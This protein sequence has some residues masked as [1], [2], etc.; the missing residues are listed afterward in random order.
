MN[1]YDVAKFA[2]V[3]V[4]TVSRVINGTDRVSD[5]TRK[6]VEDAIEKLNFIPNDVARALASSKTNYIGIMV[7]NIRN[8]FDNQSAYALERNLKARGIVS[9]LCNTSDNEN[10]KLDYLKVLRE[11]KVD[12]IITVGSTYGEKDFLDELEDISR[13]I[14]IVM[15]N[16]IGEKKHRN[17]IYVCCDEV[18]AIDQSLSFFKK[19]GY[20]KPIFISKGHKNQTRAYKAKKTGFIE[21]LKKNYPK[22]D[23]IEFVVKDFNEDVDQIVSLIKKEKIDCIQFEL[24]SL[25]VKFYKYFLKNGIRVPEDIGIC[26]FDNDDITNY[27]YKPISSIDQNIEKQAKIAIENLFRLEKGEKFEQINLIKAKFVQKQSI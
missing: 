26:G 15:L 19:K 2:D 10:E 4:A 3:S 11:K 17:M 16:V 23:F 6:K 13:E 8:Y 5:K 27:T 9:I 25:A 18:D 14:P 1:I 24:D 22:N 12:A 7:G 21:S 20:K